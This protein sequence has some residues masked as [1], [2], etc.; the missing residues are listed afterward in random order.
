VSW[1]ACAAIVCAAIA[2][3]AA[4]AQVSEF[5]AHVWK[6]AQEDFERRMAPIEARISARLKELFGSVIIPSLTAA[7]GPGRG[8]DRSAAGASLIQPQQVFSEV[9][10]YGS[11]LG[12]KNIAAALQ[13]GG[14]R[15]GTGAGREAPAAPPGQRLPHRPIYAAPHGRPA[16]PPSALAPCGPPCHPPPLPLQAEKDSLAKQVDRHLDAVQ[17]RGRGG[18]AMEERL[19]A[20]CTLCAALA[21]AC[22]YAADARLLT[23][24][25]T[26]LLPPGPR[27]SS[28]R[29]ATRPAAAARWRRW[30]A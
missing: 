20:S 12:R 26:R 13:V 3:C 21:A 7:I 18:W 29:T 27:P 10:R 4:A 28:T 25:R 1:A 8:G 16:F 24:T 14:G 30:G 2:P 22:L 15:A 11:L 9:K 19:E 17:V 23:L 5:T 6:A